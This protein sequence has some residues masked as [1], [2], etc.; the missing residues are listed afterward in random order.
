MRPLRLR[1]YVFIKRVFDILVSGTALL[2][3]APLLVIV[4]MLIAVRLG[5]PILFRQD[6]PGLGGRVFR[7]IKFR[8]MLNIDQE[9][10][11]VTNEQRMTSF[12][13]QLRAWSLDELPS[14]WNVFRGDMSLVGPRP[15]LV[16]YLPL[17]STEEARRHDVRPGLTGL[18]QV[19]GRNTLD[20][21]R[22]FALDITYVDN[23][24]IGLDLQILAMTVKKVFRRDGITSDGHV[25]GAPFVGPDET[26]SVATS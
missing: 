2:F 16:K 18:A 19:N 21:A 26:G 1:A 13:S 5:R 6:R 7:L 8:T 14:L 11:L 25:V 22:R 23:R 20:W 9:R 17:Y 15:L 4:A 10:G 24:S 3:L 12:G